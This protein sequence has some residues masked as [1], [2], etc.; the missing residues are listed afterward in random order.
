MNARIATLAA[1]V[2]AALAAA[3]AAVHAQPAAAMGQPLPDTALKDGTVVVRVIAGDRTNAVTGAEVTISISAPDGQGT[4]EERRARTDA[5]GRA[6]FDG[7]AMGVLIKATVPGEDGAVVGSTQ[8]PMPQ[9]GGVR[10]MLSTKPVAAEATGGAP[11]GGG[12]PMMG[13]GGAGGPPMS[14]RVMSG[15][16]RPEASDPRDTITARISYDDF[17]DAASL[18]DVPVVLVGYRHDQATS[19]Q[20]ARTDA[21]GRAVW[22]GLDRRGATTYFA[23]TLLPRNGGFDRLTSLPIMLDGEAG[24]RL[25]LSGDKRTATTPAID[26]LSRL[27]EQP[28]TAPVPDGVVRVQFAGVPEAGAQAE[29]IDLL[30]GKPVASA[31]MADP[32]VDLDSAK[33]AVTPV[34]ADPALAPGALALTLTHEGAPLTDRVVTLLPKGAPPGTAPLTAALAGGVATFTGVPAGEVELAV[35]IDADVTARATLT[36]TAAGGKATVD[37]QW[38]VRGE[39]GAR[40]AGLP[41]GPERVYA[42]VTTMRNQKYLSAPFQLAPG[43]GASI[44]VLIMPRVLLQWSLTSW[45]DDKYLGVRGT[46]G[47]R[48]ASWAPYLSGTDERPDDLIVP[49]PRGFTGAIVRDDFQAMV[50][51]D[52]T[53]G[54]VIR[55]PIPPG[56][57]QFVAGFSLPVDRGHV[58]WSLP[59]PLGTFESG[60][61]IKRAGNAHVDLPAEVTGIKVE[62]AKDERGE[63]MVLSPINILP[64]K[65]MVFD[66]RD[67]PSE[68]GWRVVGR[69]LVGV[70]VLLLLVLGGVLALWRPQARQAPTGKFEALLDELA[71]LE[72]KGADPARREA[73][74]RQ[75]EDL[76]AKDERRGG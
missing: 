32:L 1:V 68:A 59:L 61:E 15:Q 72:A 39:G 69:R 33:L 60:I 46:F 64:G 23:M 28:K 62:T 41:A 4:P 2:L 3:P 49:L 66:I 21:S 70:V 35:A 29:V 40:I 20:V 76:Y 12:A 16:P 65:T 19:A 10:V 26:D 30:T 51:V 73:L 6:T 57:L 56:G 53:K 14:P 9:A 67:L 50:G 22:R 47:V 74:M 63:W 38:L 8:F 43:R 52:P 25:M 27:D 58:R 48:N 34:T 71:A 44:T 37:V 7:L 42:V 18:A 36:T 54:F 17:A 55:R 24:V 11:G 13:G 45:L 75:L 31:P 5:E